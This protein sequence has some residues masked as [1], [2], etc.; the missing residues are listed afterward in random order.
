MVVVR[1]VVIVVVLLVAIVASLGVH[2]LKKTN[3]H[4]FCLT[5]V[6]V[7]ECTTVLRLFYLFIFSHIC[8]Y[9]CLLIQFLSC[10]EFCIFWFVSACNVHEMT[11]MP[12]T[13]LVVWC[14]VGLVV[15]RLRFNFRPLS[16]LGTYLR[17]VGSNLTLV[18]TP[19]ASPPFP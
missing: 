18:R 2:I 7:P 6:Y 3:L 10:T 14:S 9:W 4:C 19:E 1:I 13:P 12:C 16:V 8:L 15:K 17:G 11:T 5:A